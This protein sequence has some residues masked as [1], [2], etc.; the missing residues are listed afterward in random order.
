MVARRDEM[1]PYSK[2][3]TGE[4]ERKTTSQKIILEIE[5]ELTDGLFM[6]EEG[7]EEMENAL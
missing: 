1:R 4:L 6:G 7:K 5:I 2:V 3:V